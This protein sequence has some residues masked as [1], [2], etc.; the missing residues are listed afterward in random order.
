VTT[1]DIQKIFTKNMGSLYLLA[2]LLTGDQ[3]KAEQCFVASVADSVS[4]TN[5]FRQWAHAWAKRAIIQNAVR[6]THPSLGN[7]NLSA[8]ND[9]RAD[10]NQ[11]NLADPHFA[12]VLKL[13]DF[14]RFVFVI[15]VLER[16]SDL[17]CALLLGYSVQEIRRARTKAFERLTEFLRTARFHQESAT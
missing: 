13:Q 5:A 11:P 14:D 3:E 15:S 16:Y 4:A 9:F 8:A 1:E 12:A 2:L 7:A 10:N 17:S 6:V